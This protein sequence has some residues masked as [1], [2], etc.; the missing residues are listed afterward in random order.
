MAAQRFFQD[1]ADPTKLLSI[2]PATITT[3]TER[4]V[5]AADA[6][7]DMRSLKGSQ[8]LTSGTSVTLD[9][10]LGAYASITAGHNVSLTI[11]NGQVGFI[12]RLKFTQDA[13]GGRT[14]TLAN[15]TLANGA[16]NLTANAV[17][18]LNI[19]F[20][21]TSYDVELSKDDLSNYY[22]KNETDTLFSSLVFKDSVA[23]ATTAN[24]ALA[25][26]F[27]AGDTIDGYVLVAGDRIL[28]K[29]QTDPIENGIYVVQATGAPVRATDADTAAELEDGAAVYVLNGTIGAASGWLMSSI[30]P[31]PGTDP[32]TWAQFSS[33]AA[34]ISTVFGRTGDI[35]ATSGDYS[36]SLITFSPTGTISSSDVQNAIAELGTEKL[37]TTLTSAQ[38]FVGSAGNVATG[39]AMSGDATISNAG[40]V[41]VVSAS[42]T[43]AGKVEL[44]TSAEV[45][46]GSDTIRATTPA[47]VNGYFT[48]LVGNATGVQNLGTFTGTIIADS[49]T[50]KGALQEL[51]TDLDALQTA[52]GIAAAAV[53]FGTFTGTTIAD[54]STAKVALQALETSVETKLATTLTSARIFVGSAGN[55]ATGVVVSGDATINNAGAVTIVSAS[56]TAAGKVELATAGEALAVTS[57]TL[58]VTPLSLAD[59]IFATTTKEDYTVTNLTTDRAFD[60]NNVTLQELADIVGSLINDLITKGVVS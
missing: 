6:N 9:L 2:D 23:V 18:Y 17:T 32:I 31:I 7:V 22:T 8:T 13:T 49:S 1:N 16:V 11:S 38:I 46:T 14:L 44:A 45:L 41:T 15:G 34:P 21:G 24:G 58:A 52:V 40:A 3:G 54:N 5:T 43:V 10:A 27:E 30:S 12:G 56:T 55:V 33:T 60:A 59:L 36:A 57:G 35:V 39:V 42:A 20:N 25:T 37:A 51:E 47:G 26:A 29:N 50:V 53:N 48:A 4:V 19:Y 28:I